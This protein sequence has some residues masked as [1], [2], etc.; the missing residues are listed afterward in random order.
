[1]QDYSKIKGVYLGS[2]E[3]KMIVIIDSTIETD[4]VVEWDMVNNTET[5]SYD[6]GKTYEIFFD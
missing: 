5:N 2:D 6:V 1:M 3:D 4:L